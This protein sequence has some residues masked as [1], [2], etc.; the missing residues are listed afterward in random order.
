[1][2][3][4]LA[5]QDEAGGWEQ[6]VE[7]LAASN[8][9]LARRA[10]AWEALGE[11]NGALR[12][13]Q[14]T[15]ELRAAVAAALPEVFSGTPGL[16]AV[17]NPAQSILTVDGAWEWPPG[18]SYAPW[19]TP[20]EC[21]GLSDGGLHVVDASPPD[22]RC[23]HVGGREPAAYV[24]AP[25]FTHGELFG[26]LHVGRFGGGAFDSDGGA[27][28]LA[29]AAVASIEQALDTLR[30]RQAALDQSVR[31]LLTGLFN[32]RY[33]VESLDRELALARREGRAVA[34]VLVRIDCLRELRDAHGL[35]AGDAL[36]QAVSD[37]LRDGVRLSDIVSRWSED[38]FLLVMPGAA[39][40]AARQR[41]EAMRAAFEAVPIA[42]GG[43]PLR[44]GLSVGVAAFPEHGATARDLLRLAGG[45]Q[46]PAAFRE[47]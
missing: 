20:D 18:A 36:L 46:D 39:S 28:K 13:C 30:L 33:V 17:Y 27:L 24:C 25:V 34:V 8:A 5:R 22:A 16:F 4:A 45:A 23:A 37:V 12:R 19:F 43:T 14:S 21:L 47:A 6:A 9:E 7:R 11:M 15:A 38:E 29:R 31:D 10:Q 32:R 42:R 1:M 44:A 3:D 26:L 35:E 40:G 2:K 41:A